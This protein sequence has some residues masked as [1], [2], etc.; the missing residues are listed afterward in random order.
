MKTMRKKT[1]DP[2]KAVANIVGSVVTDA[3]SVM[4]SK[5]LIF[6]GIGRSKCA[7]KQRLSIWMRTI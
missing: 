1:T 7:T 2:A 6:A 3:V 4:Q 5:S